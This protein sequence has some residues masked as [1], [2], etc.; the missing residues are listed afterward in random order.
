VSCR[1]CSESIVG[2]FALCCVALRHVSQRHHRHCHCHC[3][4]TNLTPPGRRPAG[5]L[6]PGFMYLHT[7]FLTRG[8]L[9]STWAVLRLFGE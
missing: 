5:L 6:F 7:L 2:T 1:R 3:C 4:A 8:R 9:E